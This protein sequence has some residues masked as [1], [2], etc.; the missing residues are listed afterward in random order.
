LNKPP[1]FQLYAADFYMDTLGWTNEE[2]GLYFRLLMAEWVNGPLPNDHY[3]LSKMCQTSLKKFTNNF[4]N[5]SPKFIQNGNGFLQNDRL[6]KT[7][8]DQAHFIE[9]QREKGKI[10]ATQRWEGHIAVAKKRLQPEGKPE[11]ASSSSS[12]IKKKDIIPKI[13]FLDSVFLTQ[14]EYDKLTGKHGKDKTDRAI[15]ILN[16][17]IMSK[18][19]KYKSHYHTL[20]GWPMKEVDGN[21]KGAN[22]IVGG[23]ARPWIRRP[24]QELSGDAQRAI[25]DVKRAEREWAAKQTAPNKT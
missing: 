22:G 3:R 6:E 20:I 12:S 24:G 9:M 8:S 25:D 19:Y 10:R 2:I 7:R 17:G 23:D 4:K 13:Q 15:E 18:G 5:V 16:N 14:I 11:N 21:G 1:A